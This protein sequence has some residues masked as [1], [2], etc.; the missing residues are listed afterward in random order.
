MR[1][2]LKSAVFLT[3]T[4]I[5][6]LFL[7]A[8]GGAE[9]V[10]E[11]GES[12]SGSDEKKTEETTEG[13]KQGGDLVISSTGSPTM[14]NPLYTSDTTSGIVEGFIYNGLTKTAP[15]G[16]KEPD[17]ATEWDF[18]E[19][20]TVLTFKLR[21]D[22]YF[23]D[24]EKFTADDVVF[25]YSL[26]LHEDYTGPRAT[27]FESVEKIEAI[28]DY[29]VEIILK[30]P[31]VTFLTKSTGYGILPEHI[32]GDVPVA[33]IG[34]HEFN[35]KEPIGTGP[36]KFVEWKQGQHVLVEANEDYFDGRPNFDTITQKIVDDSNAQLVQFQAG[37]IDFIGVSSDNLTAAQALVDRGEAEMDSILANSYTYIGYNHRK[38]MFQDKRVRQALS[39]AIDKE[40]FIETVMH[41]NAIAAHHPGYPE[42]WA[43]NEDTMEFDYDPD[44][45]LE[46]LAEA[47]WEEKNEDGILVNEDGEEF[48][49]TLKLQQGNTVRTKLA[50]YAQEQ[51]REIGISVDL[52]VSEWSA[53]LK[54]LDER[55]FDAF[56]LGLSASLDPSVTTV[57]HS[58]Q[59]DALNRGGYNNPE[60]DELMIESDH[61][62]DEKERAEQ[63]KEI[64]A[65]IAEDQPMTYIFFAHN[66]YIYRPGLKGMIL[67]PNSTYYNVEEWYFEDE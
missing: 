43:F 7:V 2:F 52:N 32:L 27:Y 1:K 59:E 8:C 65:I 58:S 57:Y 18:N 4:I 51:W 31:D 19:D 40:A 30:S 60:L 22:V 55:D 41:G 14:F 5:F 13:G 21:D 20:G 34:R 63:I 50:E 61:T 47:G 15:D 28:D 25:T 16:S 37:D 66:N 67:H 45:A 33:D 54:E 35:T 44:K 26:P 11:E 38:P 17:L 56:I 53:Y 23:H 48:K 9:E 39:Y 29:T 49:F 12:R 62:T 36:F 64:Q 46:L 10:S 6:T 24:G 3:I 42:G